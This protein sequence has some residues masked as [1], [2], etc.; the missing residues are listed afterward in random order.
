M[1][2][3]MNDQRAGLLAAVCL[4]G[5]TIAPGAI[6][7]GNPNPDATA[8][9]VGLSTRYPPIAFQKDGELA[10]LEVDLARGV[11]TEI[12]KPITFEVMEFDELIPALEAGKIDVI[13]SG[14]SVTQKRS[15][16][17]AFV[18]PYM[19]VGQM[20]LIRA[21]DFSRFVDK[22]ALNVSDAK[23]GFVQ[24]TTGARYVAAALPSASK[25]AVGTSEEGVKALRTKSVDV[26]IHDAPTVW[27]VSLDPKET[28]L[29]AL[30]EPLTEEYLA[31]AVRKD[32][33]NLK[34]ALDAV[35]KRWKD[36]RNMDS[37]VNR[38]IPIR[39]EIKP[40]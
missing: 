21:G 3:A 37:T 38:W 31:W 39:V 35:V 24:G 13:M 23:V 40:Q 20:A 29:L 6:A 15:Q 8:L 19:R 17:V 25:V 10:G 28:E 7:Q 5:M 9:R 27:R 16:R 30:Y 33:T 1:R 26:F 4:L 2:I 22:G 18:E 12:G 11:S 36:N 32:D 14:M 34:G